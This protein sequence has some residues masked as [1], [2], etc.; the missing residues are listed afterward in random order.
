MLSL[1]KIV[2]AN[3]NSEGVLCVPSLSYISNLNNQYGIM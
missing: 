2:A 3:F 1:S